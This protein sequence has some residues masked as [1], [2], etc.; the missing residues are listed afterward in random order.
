[1]DIRGRLGEF[2]FI[3]KEEL[4]VKQ[5][6]IENRFQTTE[7]ASGPIQTESAIGVISCCVSL[8]PI[9]DVM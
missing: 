7:D 5:M 2:S 3:L 4:K 6:V 9:C 8:W 1:M